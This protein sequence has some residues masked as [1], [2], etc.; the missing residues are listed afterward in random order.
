MKRLIIIAI[1][2]WATLS[3]AQPFDDPGGVSGGTGG[4]IGGSGSPGGPS[5]GG[6]TDPG[7]PVGDSIL[8]E[9]GSYALLET[10]DFI[11]KE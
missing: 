8:L 1:L 4:T 11:L 3:F 6:T 7:G 2:L 9:T 10:S 5:T